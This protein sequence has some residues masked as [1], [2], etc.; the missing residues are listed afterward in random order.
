MGPV[1][2]GGKGWWLASDVDRLLSED[3]FLKVVSG[4]HSCNFIEKGSTNGE[5]HV[6]S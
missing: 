3:I 2:E 5:Q 6:T 4:S 1:I